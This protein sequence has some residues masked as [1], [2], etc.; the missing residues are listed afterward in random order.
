MRAC[1]YMA[2]KRRTYISG[3][4]GS[5]QPGVHARVFVSVCLLECARAC[6][7]VLLCARART[8][9]TSRGVNLFK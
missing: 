3:C 5:L 8:H 9:E 7:G 6:V 1:V 2:A 4:F